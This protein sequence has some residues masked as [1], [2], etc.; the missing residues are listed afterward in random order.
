[1]ISQARLEANR[2]NAKKSTGPRSE[3]GKR[4]S[5]LNAITHG[6]TARIALLPDEDPAAFDRRMIQWVQQYRPQND[7]ELFQAE[8]AAYSAWLVQRSRRAQSARLVFKAQTALDEKQNREERESMELAL[9]LFRLPGGGQAGAQGASQKQ[10]GLPGDCLPEERDDADHP[11]L[12]VLGLEASEMGCRWLLDRWSE[13]K[14]VIDDEGPAWQTP[15]RFKAIRLLRLD[16]R[17]VMHAPAVITILQACQMLDPDAGNLVDAYWNELLAANAGWSMERLRA[18]IPEMSLPA[19]QAAARQELA[20]IVKR[21]IDRLEFKLKEHEEI[22]ELE[23]KYAAHDA[24]SIIARKA[25]ECGDTKQRATD[26][27]TGTSAMF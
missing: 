18:W 11:A 15:E 7:G 27:W 19:D 13:L 12:L 20:D 24:H 23:A 17:D 2:R 3:E 25:S 26:T 16:A 10:E 21:E 14:A 1:M 6:M 4:R 8:R 22:G 9:R 5:S